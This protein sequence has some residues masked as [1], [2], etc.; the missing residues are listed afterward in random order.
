MKIRLF[1]KHNHQLLQSMCRSAEHRI[2]RIPRFSRIFSIQ[3][4]LLV[5]TAV[6]T[7]GCYE[8]N[9]A[10]LPGRP[11][12]FFFRSNITVEVAHP[13]TNLKKGL[14]V[15]LYDS[16]SDFEDKKPSASKVSD[17]LGR[18]R[19]ENVRMGEWYI[20][21]TI[22]GNPPYYGDTLVEAFGDTNLVSILQL[23]PVVR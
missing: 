20:D 10:R 23:E 9:R 16:I 1:M 12:V 5:V 17:S 2:N 3:F 8:D 6:L 18:V 14:V 7:W 22:P 19:F 15:H 4:L 11:P 21:C 13:N